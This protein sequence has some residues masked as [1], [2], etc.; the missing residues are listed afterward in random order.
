MP[1][2]A[3]VEFVENLTQ[4]LKGSDHVLVTDYQGLDSESLYE[5]RTRLRGLG[6]KYKIVKNRLARLAFK[7][8][9]WEG[10]DDQ[11]KGPTA[12]AYNSADVAAL[13]K[14]M[15]EFGAKRDRFKVKGGFLFGK[16]ASAVDVRTIASLPSRDV[17]IA[18]LAMRLNSP[19]QT[20]VSTLIEPVRALHAALSAVGKKKP[21]APAA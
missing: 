13:A 4:D 19:L 8:V 11:L 9:G 21:A 20:F 18:T 14:L 7:N 5:L 17:M 1:N 3:N 10:L 6:A 15:Q 12:I 16:S 2:T